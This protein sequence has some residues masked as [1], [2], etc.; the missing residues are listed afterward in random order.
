MLN[1]HRDG[2]V[3]M[4][5]Y[6]PHASSIQNVGGQQANAAAD[7]TAGLLHTHAW[8]VS[9]SRDVCAS[10][11]CIMFAHDAGRVLDP[12]TTRYVT[13][14]TSMR[15]LLRHSPRIGFHTYSW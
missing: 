13:P 1:I 12:H 6:I 4:G 15:A 14:T 9:T 2:D 11:A 5:G 8:H 10:T 7:D 3:M